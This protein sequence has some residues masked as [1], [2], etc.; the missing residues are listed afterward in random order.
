M[1]VGAL[2]LQPAFGALGWSTSAP[3]CI[4]IPPYSSRTA[5]I[6]QYTPKQ[7]NT[8]TYSL[9]LLRMSI[10]AL[11]TCRAIKNF[12]E[13]TS[14]WFNILNKENSVHERSGY[15][16]VARQIINKNLFMLIFS[17][18]NKMCLLNTY[19]TLVFR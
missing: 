14:S 2:M 9:Q 5:P 18:L 6:R 19:M 11:K 3:T 13:V 7:S 15:Q 4:R 8:P 1:Q 10:I 16:P 12:H 17:H